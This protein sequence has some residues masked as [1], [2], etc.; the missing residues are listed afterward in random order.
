M[1]LRRVI[2]AFGVSAVEGL[3]VFA[4]SHLG[5][6]LKYAVEGAGIV[7]SAVKRDIDD[8]PVGLPQCLQRFTDP[9]GI[10]VVDIIDAGN[11]LEGLGTVKDIIPEQVG[12][13]RQRDILVIMPV[14]I[15]E[16]ISDA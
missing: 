7:K 4:R 8:A 13:F 9:H 12:R 3:E 6:F 1:I 10:Q 5:D 14:D 11:R 15:V 16:Q 2:Q